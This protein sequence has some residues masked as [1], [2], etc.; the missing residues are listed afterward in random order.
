M[1]RRQLNFIPLPILA[2]PIMLPQQRGR[3]FSMEDQSNIGASQGL[4]TALEKGTLAAVKLLGKA[5]RFLG[6]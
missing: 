6:T 2:V 4:K 5:D 1:D 3:A